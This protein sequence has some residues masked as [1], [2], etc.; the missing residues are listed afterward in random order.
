MGDG[1]C[2]EMFDGDAM[3]TI[4]LSRDDAGALKQYL[5]Y[6]LDDDL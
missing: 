4:Q 2:V 3:A 5:Q 1:V 6:L